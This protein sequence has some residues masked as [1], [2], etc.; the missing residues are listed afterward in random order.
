MNPLQLG[1]VR[2]GNFEVLG[3]VIQSLKSHL[4]AISAVHK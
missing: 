1:I 2:K 3:E 4:N